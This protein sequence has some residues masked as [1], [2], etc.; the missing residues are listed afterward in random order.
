MALS[1]VSIV[2]PVLG[3]ARLYRLAASM[4]QPRPETDRRALDRARAITRL[5]SA[6]ARRTPWAGACLQRSLV[7]WGMLRRRGID[8]AIRTGVRKVDGQFRAHAW[9][10]CQGEALGEGSQDLA[11]EYVEVSWLPIAPRP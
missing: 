4:P 5:V 9:V 6:A 8:S 10:Q 11:Q 7:L 2:L 3:V 1:T